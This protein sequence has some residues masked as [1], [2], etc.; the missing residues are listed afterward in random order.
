M[1][2]AKMQEYLVTCKGHTGKALESTIER[3]LKDN[4]TF[5]FG[6]FLALQ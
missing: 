4:V 1:A 2:S 6:E 3:M 5:V